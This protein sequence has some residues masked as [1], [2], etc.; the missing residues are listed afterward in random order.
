MLHLASLIR[1]EASTAL[2]PSRNE[3]AKARLGA[4]GRIDSSTRRLA[5]DANHSF[6]TGHQVHGLIRRR[7]RWCCRYLFSNVSHQFRTPLTLMLAPLEDA[8]AAPDS[9]A[10]EQREGLDLAHR[11]SV[12]LLKLVNTHPGFLKIEA[13]RIE[14]CYRTCPASYR[15]GNSGAT[16][17]RLVE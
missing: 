4:D 11:N 16:I 15:N 2:G 12:R 5:G 7:A 14:A 3:A 9:P 8:L 1:V 10:T 6:A 13:G 17:E